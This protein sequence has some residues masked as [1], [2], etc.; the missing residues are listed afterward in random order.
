MQFMHKINRD[1]YEPMYVGP[2]HVYAHQRYFVHSA[3]LFSQT[4]ILTL[5]QINVMQVSEFMY[6]MLIT[7]CPRYLLINLF[8]SLVLTPTMFEHRIIISYRPIFCRTNIRQCSIRHMG[9]ITWNSIPININ[10]FYEN[11]LW[12]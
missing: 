8:K 6:N 11:F 4:G 10:S 2:M 1:I 9:A 7:Y 12:F 3:D 5:S